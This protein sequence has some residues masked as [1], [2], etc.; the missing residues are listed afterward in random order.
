MRGI[1]PASAEHGRSLEG[2]PELRVAFGLG[3]RTPGRALRAPCLATTLASTFAR[4]GASS[5]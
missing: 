2:R 4:S 5:S 1:F 3:A